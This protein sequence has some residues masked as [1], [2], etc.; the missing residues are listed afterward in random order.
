MAL[1][2]ETLFWSAAKLLLLG[3]VLLYFGLVLMVYR[4][5]GSR[6]RLRIEYHDPGRSALNLALW[7]GVKALAGIVH[8]AKAT[9]DMLSD[10]SA[11]VGEWYL[12]HHEH[13][14]HALHRP[15]FH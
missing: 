12:R 7:L 9:L 5:E 3:A 8:A 4:L 11:E 14:V 13:A 10:T 2:F 6:L 15:R 1:A